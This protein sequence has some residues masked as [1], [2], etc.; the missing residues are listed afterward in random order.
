MS[1][2]KVLM[3]VGIFLAG[4]IVAKKTGITLPIIG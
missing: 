2:T 1:M 3:A 4:Y